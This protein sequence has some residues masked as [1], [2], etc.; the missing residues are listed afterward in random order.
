MFF[1]VVCGRAVAGEPSPK[2]R[3][4]LS[5]Y[6]LE[7][8]RFEVAAL[9]GPEGARLGAFAEQAWDAWRGPFGLPERWPVGITVR[10]AP[11]SGWPAGA[12]PWR[13]AAEPGG[14]VSVW[15]RQEPGLVEAWAEAR[16][17]LSALAAGA[18]QRQA[19]FIGVPPERVTTP[20]WLGAAAAEAVVVRQQPSLS[21]A[22]LR[23]AAALSRAPGLKTV[24]GW[25]SAGAEVPGEVRLAAYGVWVWL[26]AEGTRSGAWRRFLAEVLAGADAEA[27]LVKNFV[28]IPGRGSAQELELACQT[29]FAQIARVK[30]VPVLEP[31][32]SRRWLEQINRF[33]VMEASGGEQV[34]QM[35]DLWSL[36]KLASVRGQ[37]EARSTLVAAN[38]RTMHP[39]YRNAA[40]SW[41]RAC[42]AILEGKETVCKSAV[43]EWRQDMETGLLL[44]SASRRILDEA[45]GRAAR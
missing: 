31:Y 20:A 26:Q 10:L 17:Q 6:G 34:I 9:A 12:P 42:V 28:N 5:F 27:A 41:G 33:V 35:G 36:R 32:E 22:W 44:E 18:M 4:N 2:P 30:N 43:D 38:L 39:F 21:D 13:V 7:S 29:A 16:L 37:L 23:E 3:E 8:G 40:V 15:V 45:D 11:A 14:I 1:G 24:L 19:I 25:K